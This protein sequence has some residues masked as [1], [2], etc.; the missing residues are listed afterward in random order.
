[1]HFGL[2]YDSVKFGDLGFG[3]LGFGDLPRVVIVGCI[4]CIMYTYRF[5]MRSYTSTRMSEQVPVS[6]V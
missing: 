4:A 1:M 3:E 5:I 2:L 6:T